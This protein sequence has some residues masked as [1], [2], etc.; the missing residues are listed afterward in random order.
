[1]I[2]IFCFIGV[3]KLRFLFL[4][5]SKRLLRVHKIKHF[6]K[7]VPLTKINMRKLGINDIKK[8]LNKAFKSIRITSV[9]T[10]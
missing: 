4:R 2:V 6:D 5:K 10:I 7:K 1:M 3:F 9:K 8:R